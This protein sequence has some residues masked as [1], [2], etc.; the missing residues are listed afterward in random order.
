MIRP[1]SP[2]RVGASLPNLT[3]GAAVMLALALGLDGKLKAAIGSMRNSFAHKLE[4]KRLDRR[5]L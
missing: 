4:M 2:G 5:V 3:Q 1:M